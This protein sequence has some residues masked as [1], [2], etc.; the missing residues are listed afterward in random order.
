MLKAVTARA[1]GCRRTKEVFKFMVY[2]QV[3]LYEELNRYRFCLQTTWKLVGGVLGRPAVRDEHGAAPLL[4]EPAVARAAS[5]GDQ[6][7]LAICLHWHE[8]ATLEQKPRTRWHI[9][10]ALQ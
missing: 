8:G 7:C 5:A 4:G 2:R 3:S 6:L 10:A 1:R 9:D